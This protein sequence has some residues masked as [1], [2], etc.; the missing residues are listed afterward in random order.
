MRTR[1]AATRRCTAGLAVSK[2][3]AYA[4]NAKN[5][6]RGTASRSG[7]TQ[8]TSLT[9]SD[10][11]IRRQVGQLNRC[12]LISGMNFTS[13]ERYNCISM[14]HRGQ[15]GNSMSSSECLSRSITIPPQVSDES[16]AP[17]KPTS[18]RVH[19]SCGAPFRAFCRRH[20]GRLLDIGDALRQHCQFRIQSKRPL[21]P[22]R[23]TRQRYR[24]TLTFGFP[25]QRR[26]DEINHRMSGAFLLEQAGH[27]PSK[28]CG[29]PFKNEHKW[30][31]FVIC[32]NDPPASSPSGLAEA[33]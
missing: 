29:I 21:R 16:P 23:A 17:H 25:I 2:A 1:A 31:S 24:R 7:A 19:A 9:V 11:A 10:S 5:R 4:A 20:C 33:S 8:A 32:P 14:P 18:R 30:S 22:K 13:S 26:A 12:K 27:T 28:R 6:K 15:I 3:K